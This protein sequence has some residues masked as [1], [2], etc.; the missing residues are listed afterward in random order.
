LKITVWLIAVIAVVEGAMWVA[1]LA[2]QRD[3]A[4]EANDAVLVAELDAAE[5]RLSAIPP[6]EW[7]DAIYDAKEEFALAA[8]P[9]TVGGRDEGESPAADLFWRG[10]MTLEDAAWATLLE[11]ATAARQSLW[12]QRDTTA[13]RVG[14]RRFVAVDGAAYRLLAAGSA[15]PPELLTSTARVVII[16][17]VISLGAAAIAVWFI[18]GA[19]VRPL[20]DIE[21]LATEMRPEHMPNADLLH[22]SGSETTRLQQEL[23]AAFERIEEGYRAQSRFLTNVSHE[24]KTPISVIL[25]QAQTLPRYGGLPERVVEF[26]DSVTSEMRRLGRMIESFLLLSRVR[27]GKTRISDRRHLVNE[28]VMDAVINSADMAELHRV[29]VAPTLAESESGSDLLCFGDPYLLQTALDNLLRNAIRFSP[30]GERVEVTVS[31]EDGQAVIRVRDYG[32]GV[33]EDQL[34]TIFDRFAQADDEHRHGRGNWLGL[35][36]ARSIAELH[37]GSVGARNRDPGAEFM[38]RLPLMS[39]SR[40]AAPDENSST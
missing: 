34:E 25:A 1:V 2:H 33:P 7:A 35:E 27:E 8:I 36:I 16:G 30:N 23:S 14:S 21:R 15:E 10:G 3:K 31:E 39:D 32:P 28:L 24:L 6:S 20:A 11:A 17:R 18:A 4:R 13:L 5:A 38:I 22:E 19:A 26:H 12:T 40:A 29:R 37:G 9:E